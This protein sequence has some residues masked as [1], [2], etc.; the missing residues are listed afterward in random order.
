MRR[1][2]LA[3]DGSDASHEALEFAVAFA[4]QTDAVLHVVVVRPVSSQPRSPVLDLES[5]KAATRIADAAVVRAEQR[6]VAAVAHVARGDAGRE[7]AESADRLQADMVVV[8]ARGLGDAED[9]LGS[10]SL[11]VAMRS[12]VPV[13][14]V[15][16]RP[17]HAA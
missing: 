15:R 8:G 17:A 10:V 9:L 16:E 2:L 4:R 1:V 3:T 14:V 7:I 12:P 11:A 6:G 5:V 13:T